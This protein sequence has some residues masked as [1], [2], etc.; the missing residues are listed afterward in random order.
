MVVRIAGPPHRRIVLFDYIPSRPAEALKL[1]GSALAVYSPPKRWC[2]GAA[3]APR[4]SSQRSNSGSTSFRRAC[5]QYFE[6]ELDHT[7][8]GYSET[9]LLWPIDQKLLTLATEQ[10][11]IY[12]ARETRFHLGEVPVKTHS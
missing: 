5:T 3:S 4:R 8:S 7:H 9:Y 12:R 6:C 2:S 10:W 1:I 11:Q